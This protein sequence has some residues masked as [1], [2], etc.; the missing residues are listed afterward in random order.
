[1]QLIDELKEE[2]KALFKLI[3]KIKSS[4]G[5]PAS[6]SGLLLELKTLIMEHL[7]KEDSRLYPVLNNSD[8]EKVKKI[9][10]NFTR[11]MERISTIIIRFFQKHERNPDDMRFSSDFS[12]IIQLL[13]IRIERE[14]KIL[15][16]LYK[17]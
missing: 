9:S 7:K 15:F 12:K 3:S 13:K 8:D 2:H 10:Y 6:R 4:T 14:E 16:R 1:M 11:G 17:R 5:N